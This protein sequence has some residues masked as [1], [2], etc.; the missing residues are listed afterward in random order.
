MKHLT[1]LKNKKW[2]RILKL[3]DFLESLPRKRFDFSIWVGNEWKGAPDLSC[4]TTACALGWATTLPLFR[5]LG[6]RLSP[7]TRWPILNH[8]SMIRGDAPF[9]KLFGLSEATFDRLFRPLFDEMSGCLGQN[10]TPKQWA[11]HARRIVLELQ[12][13]RIV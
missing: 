1:K 12:D 11:K 9:R 4:G 2:N 13:G 7:R 6:L 5:R 3:A 8:R 10:A